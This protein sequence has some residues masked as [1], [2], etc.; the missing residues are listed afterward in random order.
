MPLSGAVIA[1]SLPPSQRPFVLPVCARACSCRSST[2][3][4]PAIVA[5]LSAEAEEAGWHGVF[6]WD[7]LQ[8]QDVSEGPTR[9]SRSRRSPPPQANPARSNGDAARTT[10]PGQGGQRTATLDRLSGGRL[11]LGVGLGSD[12]YANELS[13]TGEELDDK[14]RASMLDDS[15]Q[16]L[17][18]A[19]S[20]EPV[21][22]RGENY[23]VDGHAVSA[24]TGPAARC[25]GVGRRLSRKSQAAA[26]GGFLRRLL[27]GKP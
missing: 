8:F 15:L 1:L 12:G 22:H 24:A 23:V 13:K 17:T 4:R 16:I 7:H 14:R 11:T 10:P 26:P 9:G 18:A 5:R 2:A 21:H 27:P 25:A 19:W 6:V 3:R 20:G